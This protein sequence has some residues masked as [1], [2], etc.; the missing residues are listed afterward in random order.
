MAAPREL[1][2]RPR[3]WARPF[4]ASFRRFAV[5]V[6][7]RRLGKTSAVLN[8]HLRAAASDEWERAR[9][10]ALRPTLT[11]PQLD[12]LL[13]PPGGRH[14]AHIMPT[15]RQAK[16]AAWDK[17]K[18]YGDPLVGRRMNEG[19]LLITV[20]GG[21]KVQLFGADNPDSLRGPAFSGVSF[22]EYSQQPPNI[23]GEII[24][25]ALAD[26]LGYAIFLGTIKGRDHLFKMHES[27][28][29]N[30]SWF[31]LWQNIDTSLATE[32]GIT[33]QLL[34][35]A[36]ADD[37]D[38]IRSGVIT[39]DEFDQEWYLSPDVAAK[40]A[41]YG[42]EMKTALDDGRIRDVPY[43]PALPVDT[44]WDLGIDDFMAIWFSQSLR[45]GE[46]RLIEYY[47]NSGEGFP[48][49]AKVLSQ[50][51]YVYGKHYAPHDIEVRELGTGTSRKKVAR[52]L[53]IVF[54]V[55][56]NWGLA[57]GIDA[58]RRIL[59]RAYFEKTKCAVGLECL[60]EYRKTWNT[61]MQEFTGTPV[62]NKWSHG[63]DALRTLATRHAPPRK[64]REKSDVDGQYSYD[65][66]GG[67]TWM[68]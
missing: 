42:K 44:D 19:D 27:V 67:P 37:R 51:P 49:Y 14:Y 13:H 17:L 29:D 5:L 60:R 20:R 59:P 15:Y 18:Y 25:K 1:P 36:M 62:H 39:Q 65:L 52:A 63:A 38:L 6:C 50:R 64:E 24:S 11:E 34:E 4:H 12:E 66:G 22:D 33:I 8:H 45:S 55:A 30:P 46:I 35:Q 53:G 7:H 10:L 2:Y 9:L 28:K 41:W 40:G 57:E 23:F 31:A 26:H 48:F 58:V 68:G 61:T 56:P 43:D 3:N 21:H 32:D 16:L 47:Q 54:H